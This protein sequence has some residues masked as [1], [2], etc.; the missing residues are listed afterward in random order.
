[1]KGEIHAYA[2]KRCRKRREKAIGQCAVCFPPAIQT[3]HGAKP[4]KT[5]VEKGETVLER[6]EPTDT[7]TDHTAIDVDGVLG[8]RAATPRD[9]LLSTLP[10]TPRGLAPSLS[11]TR[12]LSH[13]SER[14]TLKSTVLAGSLTKLCTNSHSLPDITGRNCFGKSE[15]MR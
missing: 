3:R 8:G 10:R 6:V 14:A 13:V 9:N 4:R 12:V 5:D 1:M 11:P 7:N 15:H 2:V